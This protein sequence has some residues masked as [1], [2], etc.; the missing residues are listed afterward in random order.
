MPAAPPEV[1]VGLADRDD[2][3]VYRI[4]PDLALVQTVDFFTPIVDDPF[5]FGRVAAANALSDVYAMGARPITALN[6]VGFRVETLGHAVLAEI[7]RGGLDVCSRAGVAILGGHTIDDAEPK[8]G[9]AVTGLVH[10]DAIRKK[11]GGQP[12]DALLLTKP[13]GVGIASSA[14]KRGLLTEEQIH[15][16]TELMI[17]L[18]DQVAALAG[19]EVHAV[20]DVTGFGLLGHAL[21]MAV[22]SGVSVR[23]FANAVPVIDW[24]WPL[25]AQGVIPGGSKRNLTHVRP[26]LTVDAAVAPTHVAVL[27]DAVTSG[28][29]LLAVDSAAADQVAAALKAQGA[30]CAARIGELTAGDGQI[31]LLP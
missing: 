22:A 17:T 6:L 28:G 23:L 2:A 20:T 18:N 10:P 31:E 11:A 4:S 26:R 15:E 16:V 25:A 3:G 24:A 30:L 29:L 27:A 5:D 13:I 7:L 21:E 8:Y 12:G 19:P 14:L 9:L 1:L